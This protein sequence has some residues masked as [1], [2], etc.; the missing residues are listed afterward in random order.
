VQQWSHNG[1]V[2]VFGNIF[3]SSNKVQFVPSWC[4]VFSF[5]PPLLPPHGL[6]DFPLPQFPVISQEFS[7]PGLDWVSSQSQV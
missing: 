5:P 7:L 6:H 4:A 3:L 2:E 1:G